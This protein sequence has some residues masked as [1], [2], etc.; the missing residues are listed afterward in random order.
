MVSAQQLAI[1]AK[2]KHTFARGLKLLKEGDAQGSIP[3]FEKV[4]ELA[5]AR[6]EPYHD[7]AVAHNRLGH[8]DAAARNFQKAIELSRSSFAPSLFGLGMIYYRWSRYDEAEPLIQ[9]GLS[10]TPQ[11]AAGRYCLGLV[12]YSLGRTAEAQHSALESVRLD[13]RLPD[14]YLLLGHIH[15]RLHNSQ[16]VLEDVQS[17][18]ALAP[19]G[20]LRPDALA[21]RERAEQDLARASVADESH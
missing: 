4:I 13:P 1:P 3:Y 14:T 17:Y 19:H 6:F 9:R 20:P 21:L 15:Q 11:S 18:L 2:A 8:L 7:L 10:I 5:P 16:A 12:Q